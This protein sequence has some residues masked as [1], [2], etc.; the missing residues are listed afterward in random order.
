LLP[1]KTECTLW[2]HAPWKWGTANPPLAEITQQIASGMWSWEISPY[3]SLTF[4]SRTWGSNPPYQ[5]RSKNSLGVQ[6]GQVFHKD[7]G[8][9]QN[10]NPFW[11]NQ[12]MP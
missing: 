7:K 4:P 1:L 3:L 5:G 6:Q 2:S 8:A 9:R 11:S 10:L 12:C